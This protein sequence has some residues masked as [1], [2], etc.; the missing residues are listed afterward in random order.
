MVPK[1]SASKYILKLM[2]P[3]NPDTSLIVFENLTYAVLKSSTLPT[4]AI[5]LVD[6][7]PTID[8][9]IPPYIDIPDFKGYVRDGDWF[10]YYYENIGTI[11][12]QHSEL[13][14]GKQEINPLIHFHIK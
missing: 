11:T 12:E 4:P 3:V 6:P 1:L 13:F 7:E 2:S 9:S 8:P 10:R 5:D 14:N